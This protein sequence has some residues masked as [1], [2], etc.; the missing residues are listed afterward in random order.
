MAKK[1]EFWDSSAPRGASP[2]PPS[3]QITH[4]WAECLV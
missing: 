2:L 3:V 4:R 1:E